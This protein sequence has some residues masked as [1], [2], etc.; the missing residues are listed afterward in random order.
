MFQQSNKDVGKM[1]GS[2]ITEHNRVQSV[3][4][5]LGVRVTYW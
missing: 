2:K 1:K 3:R 4:K 5:I